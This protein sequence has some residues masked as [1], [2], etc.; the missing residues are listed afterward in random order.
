MPV[1][2]A[3]RSSPRCEVAN[4]YDPTCSTWPRTTHSPS[5]SSL[6]FSSLALACVS[7][8]MERGLCAEVEK[9]RVSLELHLSQT[10]THTQYLCPSL[11][12]CYFHSPL[13]CCG[14]RCRCPHCCSRPRQ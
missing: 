9:L 4:T 10:H 1:I 11:T 8:V 3:G 14:G 7:G 13:N 2:C 12:W 6:F 5:A